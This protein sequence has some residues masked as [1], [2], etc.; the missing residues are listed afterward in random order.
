MDLK[1]F[2]KNYFEFILDLNIYTISKDMSLVKIP[3][4][5]K[6][7]MDL[8]NNDS[9]QIIYDLLELLT[10]MQ[11]SIKWEQNPKAI[12]IAKFIIFEEEKL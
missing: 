7:A 6:D 9:Q 11:S 1:Q 12:I 3:I 10:D 2:I 5:W 8:Y 4:N